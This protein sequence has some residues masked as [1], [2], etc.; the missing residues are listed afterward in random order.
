MATRFV[1][2]IVNLSKVMMTLK[3]YPRI[4]VPVGM[5]TVWEPEMIAHAALQIRASQE[6][7]G[8][9]SVRGLTEAGFSIRFDDFW[10]QWK[11]DVSKQ[12]QF[13]GGDIVIQVDLKILVTDMFEKYDYR[14]DVFQLIMI[15]ELKHWRDAEDIVNGMPD[16]LKADADVMRLL[17]DSG[18]GQP[19]KL[20]DADFR[21][22]FVTVNPDTGGT[23]FEDLACDM[24]IAEHD[25][26]DHL[27]D[28]NAEYETYSGNV[29]C[30]RQNRAKS[31]YWPK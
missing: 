13:Q 14:N 10:S 21:A 4:V 12:W 20:S 11:Q 17:I 16:K 8:T 26:L 19:E 25:R 15:H 23:Q 1:P 2:K 5:T 31:V 22:W 18:K 24:M 6:Q 3:N 27:R 9:G 29:S 7:K 28:T 30:L